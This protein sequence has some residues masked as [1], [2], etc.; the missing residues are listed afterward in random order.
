VVDRLGGLATLRL[1]LLVQAVA[2][3]LCLPPLPALVLPAAAAAGFAAVGVT[4]VTLSVTREIAGA[5]ATGLWIRC[6]LAFAVVQTVVG[7]ALAALFAATGESH[8]AIFAAGFGFSLAALA[9]AV[10]LAWQAPVRPG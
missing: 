10:A 2:L 6:N 5:Q 9:A 4:A 7:F 8:L 1:W 3:A